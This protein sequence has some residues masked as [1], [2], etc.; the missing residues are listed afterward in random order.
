VQPDLY[1]T[2]PR[3]PEPSEPLTIK[4]IR[5]Y[6]EVIADHSS[7]KYCNLE[8][9][10]QSYL[11]RYELQKRNIHILVAT[12]FLAYKPTTSSRHSAYTRG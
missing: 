2:S 7:A 5:Q 1:I 12:E 3:F 11:L 4:L 6:L 8:D 9:P 10:K